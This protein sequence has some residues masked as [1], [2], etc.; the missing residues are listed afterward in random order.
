MPLILLQVL[1]CLG[2]AGS[3]AVDTLALLCPASFCIPGLLQLAD[4]LLSAEATSKPVLLPRY[5]TR[6]QP[7]PSPPGP[8]PRSTSPASPLRPTSRLRFAQAA[9][10][11]RSSL[12]CYSVASS[13]CSAH[14]R[15]RPASG[16]LRM[17]LAGCLG[18][19]RRA[20]ALGYGTRSCSS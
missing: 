6:S 1:P 9:G 15:R 13:P 8:A 11:S 20:A 18:G 17:L 14:N 10:R 19:E 4:L 7:N 2:T 5:L 16:R 12:A 3:S